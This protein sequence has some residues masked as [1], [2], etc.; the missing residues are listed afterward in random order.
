MERRQWAEQKAE[1]EA[2]RAAAEKGRGRRC[3]ALCGAR[4]GW[5]ETAAGRRERQCEGAAGL[6]GRMKLS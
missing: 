6:E 4:C 3:T 1:K 2:G 5:A